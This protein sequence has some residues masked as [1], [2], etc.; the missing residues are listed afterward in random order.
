MVK[1]SMGKTISLKLSQQE[2]NIINSIRNEGMTPSI[3]LREA[4]WNYV[5]EKDVKNKE[6]GNKEVNQ[7]N[8]FSK[9]KEN[10]MNRKGYNMVNQVNQKVNLEEDL[11]RENEVNLKVNR[12]DQSHDPF[13][14]YYLYQLH[15]QIQYLEKEIN[16][17]KNRYSTET[18][19]W[20]E[21]YQSLQTEYQTYLK[22]STK[23]IDEKFDRILF[24]IEETRRSSPPF[25]LSKSS[26][27]LGEKQK[28]RWHSQ[29][30]RM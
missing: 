1:N 29:N 16:D 30:V 6:K 21:T 15:T 14:E 25:E 12:V 23:R 24:Y 3:F 28:K 19:Y 4:L 22:E 5:Q 9:E 17:W 10:Y 18:Q 20:K 13:V 26:E 2:E 7:V 8:Q 27:S 11:L